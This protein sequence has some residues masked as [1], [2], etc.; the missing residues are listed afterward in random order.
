M[1]PSV[2]AS[3]LYEVPVLLR[4]EAEPMNRWMEHWD[5]RR[6]GLCLGVICVGAGIY[7]AGMGCWRSGL[8]AFYVALKFPLVIL[9]VTLGN[10]LLN[11]MLAPLLGLD[12]RLRQ[13]LLAMLMSFTIAA[14]VL[15]AFSPLIF[16]LVWNLP[17]MSAGGE[18]GDALAFNIIKV[19]H[20]A[21]IALAGV[22]ANLRLAQL[23]RRLCGNAAAA[24]RVLIAWLAGNLLLGSQLG[25][26]LRPFF[27]AP[28]LEVQFLRPH[29][30]Q[31][32]FYETVFR[33]L[34]D[35]FFS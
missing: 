9:L 16:F 20:V 2:T 28:F 13:S 8:Q 30:L 25:W 6:V 18:Q 34:R 15:G 11:G 35:L 19:A 5:P 22:A 26:I 27:G 7:G 3:G 17:P 4:G 23:L 31:G 14:A 1:E 33:A 29:P 10:A 24:R 12:L 21:I 32:N